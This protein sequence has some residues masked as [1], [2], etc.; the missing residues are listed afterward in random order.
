[1]EANQPQAWGEPLRQYRGRA[2]LTQEELAARR[3]Q[4][5]D[6][7][8]L[9]AGKGRGAAVRWRWHTGKGTAGPRTRSRAGCRGH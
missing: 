2:G 8:G 1:M 9:G 6:D 5:P 4:Q 3:D 7:P